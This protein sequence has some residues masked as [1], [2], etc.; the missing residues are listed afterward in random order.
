MFKEQKGEKVIRKMGIVRCSEVTGLPVI[1]IEN[2]KRIGIVKD[3]IFSPSH[4]KVSAFL[5][6]GSGYKP[7]KKVVMLEDVMSL[8]KD[9]VM[10]NSY[11]RKKIVK[12]GINEGK[13]NDKGEI[14]GLKIYS[15]S[16]EELGEVKDVLFDYQTGLVEGV[17]VSDGLFQDI[18]QGRKILPLFGKVEFSD[19]SMLVD[20][21][22]VDEMM[23]TGGGIK[24]KLLNE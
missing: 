14:R 21:E 24:K 5:L 19:E 23:N 3:V 6:E 1:C 11:S 12:K 20:R 22:A 16:G 7:Y 10:I 13:L 8:G 2:G 17:E 9:A 18:I 4:R 15:K